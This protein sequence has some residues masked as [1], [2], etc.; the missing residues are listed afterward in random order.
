MVIKENRA[1]RGQ[2]SSEHVHRA[3]PKNHNLLE[4]DRR[5]TV[6]AL[7][8]TCSTI[9]PGSL[10]AACAP[11]D[12]LNPVP[13][14]LRP[15][16]FIDIHSHIFNA[17]D[18]PVSNFIKHVVVP[19]NTLGEIA[20]ASGLIAVAAAIIEAGA[21]TGD[22]ELKQLPFL[23]PDPANIQSRDFNV[24]KAGLARLVAAPISNNVLMSYGLV[25]EQLVGNVYNELLGRTGETSSSVPQTALTFRAF[26]A[27][28]DV[29]LLGAL[30]VFAY[31]G[32]G[33][34]V[35][36]LRTLNQRIDSQGVRAENVELDSAI[37]G[38][39]I[40]QF[41]EQLDEIA[42]RITDAHAWEKRER[43]IGARALEATRFQIGL[44]SEY[45]WIAAYF[46]RWAAG[47]TRYR[48]ENAVFINALFPAESAAPNSL[49]IY[50]HAM[51][52]FEYWLDEEAGLKDAE[53]QTSLATQISVYTAIA[54]KGVGDTLFMGF[55]TFDPLR[56]VLATCSGSALTE[57]PITLLESAIRTNGFLGAKVYPP[58]GFLP[59]GNKGLSTF[60]PTV[61][62]LLQRPDIKRYGVA[63]S[64]LGRLLDD[65]LLNFYKFA[66]LHDIAIVT[67]TSGSQYSFAGAAIRPDPAHWRNALDLELL[68]QPSLRRLRLNMGHFGGVWCLGKASTTELSNNLCVPLG[69][70]D[71]AKN[72]SPEQLQQTW[73]AMVTDLLVMRNG[74][75]RMYPFLY[76]DIADF[77]Y[78][79]NPFEHG[80][81]DLTQVNLAVLLGLQERRKAVFDYLIY[82]TDWSMLGRDVRFEDYVRGFVPYVHKVAMSIGYSEKDAREVI[83]K[84]M[85]KNAARFLGIRVDGGAKPKTRQRLEEFYKDNPRVIDMLAAFDEASPVALRAPLSNRG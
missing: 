26:L 72:L 7:I 9:I 17:A 10:L 31:F 83:E 4:I 5:A 58:M 12:R 46:L 11:L 77:T 14:P 30:T 23:S 67:H 13:E 28:E 85:W 37:A 65:E 76:A 73:A 35:R 27:R 19:G 16:H 44:L 33:P 55:A 1:R 42:V 22:K 45:Y 59:Y 49:R 36:E 75:D 81:R 50:T 56:A 40:L 20:D 64:D 3:T 2:C 6:K 60:G 52:D 66:L 8:L 82:G 24:L 84:V 57:H 25:R 61:E 51:Q 15:Q 39:A 41:S 68:G 34:A 71:T 21:P 32:R 69:P 53:I 29:R 47:F 38:Q 79:S 18:L 74:N 80:Q 48:Y 43:G 54:K 63:L 78:V 70:N 62:K